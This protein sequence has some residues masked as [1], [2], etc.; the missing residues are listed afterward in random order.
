ML[1]EDDNSIFYNRVSQTL[2]ASL[3]STEYE[4]STSDKWLFF[5]AGKP[6]VEYGWKVH[7]SSSPQKWEQLLIALADIFKGSG[8][9]FKIPISWEVF[10]G[11]NGGYLGDSQVGKNITV[12]TETW[13]NSEKFLEDVSYLCQDSLAPKIPSDFYIDESSSIAVRYGEI[14]PQKLTNF[15]TLFPK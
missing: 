4:V 2:V 8:L 6:T 10:K 7:I 15:F 11:L 14:S 5:K 1:R 12:Y 13:E 3:D 9:S